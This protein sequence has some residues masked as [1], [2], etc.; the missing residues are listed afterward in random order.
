MKKSDNIAVG[1]TYIVRVSGHLVPI[2]LVE[3]SPN[4]GWYGR[5][6]TTGREIRIRTAAKLRRQV[7]A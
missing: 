4:G 1:N 7:T 5:N 2:K 6:M 3:S